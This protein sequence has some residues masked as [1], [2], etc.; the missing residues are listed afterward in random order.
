MAVVKQV[1]G[2][3]ARESAGSSPDGAAALDNIVKGEGFFLEI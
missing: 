1:F 2:G 3:R